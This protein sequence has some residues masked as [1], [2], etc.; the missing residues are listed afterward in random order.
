MVELG[1]TYP[2]LGSMAVKPERQPG[3]RVRMRS[4]RKEDLYDV[5]RVYLRA[6]PDSL[7]ALHSPQLSALAVGDVMRAPLLADP[8]SLL[9]AHAPAGE[10]VGY[11]IAVTD[12]SLV[13]HAVLFR[14]LVPKW[15]V[16]WLRGRYH[17]SPRG[18]WALLRDLLHLR[19][20]AR[21]RDADVPARIISLAVD[22][23]WQGRGIGEQLLEAAFQ[24]LRELGRTEV[25]LEVRPEN[26]A[27]RRLYEKLGFRPVGEFRDTRGPW[28]VMVA[29]TGN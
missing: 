26:L 8:G 19:G 14:W 12:A 18:A 24:R 29:S 5:A 6:F 23:D 7:R 27:A 4:A 20:T 28:I 21:M 2:A 10:I 16:R 13:L 25:R 17:L 11:V 3:P 15:L 9:V 1:Y 22:P